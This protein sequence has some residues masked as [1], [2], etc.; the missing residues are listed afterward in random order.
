[1]R[2]D[3]DVVVLRV[4]ANVL[5]M[6]LPFCFG[7]ARVPFLMSEALWPLSQQFTVP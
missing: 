3:L 7:P 4:C 1:R 2:V 6:V 5:S